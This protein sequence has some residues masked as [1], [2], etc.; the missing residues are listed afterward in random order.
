MVS[1][2]ECCGQDVLDDPNLHVSRGS[3]KADGACN[4]CNRQIDEFG[5]LDRPITKVMSSGPGPRLEVR[6]C[7]KCIRQLK[8]A[9]KD[10][11]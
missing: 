3:S 2:C 9:T 8:A 5:V 11:R 10:I 1:Q 7:H 4:F 6:F